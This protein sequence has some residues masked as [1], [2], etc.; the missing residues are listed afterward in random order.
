MTT[1]AYRSGVMAAD[2]GM[3]SGGGRVGFTQKI[4]RTLD[5]HLVAAAGSAA[6]AHAFKQW[7]L[8]GEVGDP[9]KAKSDGNYCDRGL[10]VRATGQI[11]V[12][13]EGG[14]FPVEASY[15]AMG[16]GAAEARGA[17]FC[18]AT[19]EQAVRAAIE[20]DDGTFGDITVL[21]GGME[22]DL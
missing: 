6:Y 10:I 8:G 5:G 22:C 16:S 4:A 19:A 11:E 15:V 20:H 13:E 2:T 3:S 14:M 21:R 18:G 9:P 17:M 1:I 7:A 12:Y